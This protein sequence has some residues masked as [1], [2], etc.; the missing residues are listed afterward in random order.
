MKV[1]ARSRSLL[2]SLFVSQLLF[3]CPRCIDKMF[4][5]GFVMN[6]IN[7]KRLPITAIHLHAHSHKQTCIKFFERIA[8]SFFSAMHIFCCCRQCRANKSHTLALLQHEPF[9]YGSFWIDNCNRIQPVSEIHLFESQLDSCYWHFG[10]AMDRSV[11]Y[12]FDG[13]SFCTISM[14]LACAK[15]KCA[16]DY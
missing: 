3:F 7:L 14:I 9:V 10:V 4:L 16:I 11:R 15:F 5:F 13:I 6:Q 12:R 1:S 8:Y 2:W